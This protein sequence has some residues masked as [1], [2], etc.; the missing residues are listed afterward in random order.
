MTAHDYMRSAVT[1]ID[2]L[3]GAGYAKL[4]PE[5]VAAYMQTAAAD[6]GAAIIARAIEGAGSAIASS[7]EAVAS[8]VHCAS[9]QY[10]PAS[11]GGRSHRAPNPLP[12]PL[13]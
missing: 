10:I 1:D 3:F 5:L 4:H 11:R 8:E 2:G 6:F 7:V 9:P 12:S 13:K